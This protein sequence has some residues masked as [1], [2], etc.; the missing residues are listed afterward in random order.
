MGWL[1]CYQ[2]EMEVLASWHFGSKGGGIAVV[3]DPNPKE[4]LLFCSGA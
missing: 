2:A 1:K 3:A 4:C